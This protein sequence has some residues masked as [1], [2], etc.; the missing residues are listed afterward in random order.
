V[1]SNFNLVGPAH[2]LIL[3]SVPLLAAALAQGCRRSSRAARP[4]RYCLAV[5]LVLSQLAWY[6]YVLLAQGFDL[7]DELPLNLCDVALWLT[8]VAAV[9]L[10]PWTFDIVYYVGSAGSGMALL[11]PDLWLP[12]RSY[13]SVSFFLA[14]GFTVITILTLLWGRLA[15]PRP[16]SLWRVLGIVNAYAVA[17][18]LFDAIF[19][20]N[21]MYLCQKPE[22][23]SLLSYLGP[24][25]LYLAGGELAALT[26]FWLLWLPFRNRA[27]A[28]PRNPA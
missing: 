8:V 13:A 5:F 27:H 19:K 20:A 14:H 23:V 28:G 21:Y 24:W 10:K 2:L 15:A 17:V 7:R 1:N 3:I 12:L 26:L 25:P 9:T 18:G 16:G 6:T 11:T 4:I 22:A